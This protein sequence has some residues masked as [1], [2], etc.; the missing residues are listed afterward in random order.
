MTPFE[1][2]VLG[3]LQGVTEFLPISSSGHLVVAQE[4]MGLL[5]PDILFEVVVHMGTLAS[6]LVV[7]KEVI[8][9]LLT[10]W[11]AGESKRM[12]GYLVLGTLPIALAGPV[13][14]SRVE[15][16]FQDLRLVGFAFLVTGTVLILTSLVS[17]RGIPNDS[18]R[19]FLIGVGQ[20]VALVPGISRSGITIGV[21]LL[22]GM[23]PKEAA[24]FSFLLAIP[25]LIG[26]GVLITRD[27]V[28]FGSNTE[29]VV[30]LA[31]GF[32]SAFGV[33]VISLRFLLR[34]LLK[35]RF[36]WFG[37]YCLALGIISIWM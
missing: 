15:T 13:F 33:G 28:T 35:G 10:H 36:H 34:I 1:A 18:K 4:L 11:S 29:S 14:K 17:S 25:S 30:V 5:S 19:S 6:I 7:F 16:M 9:R 2:A 26:S 32:L 20:A 37:V 24:R 21:G 3:I 12:F 31:V 23:N 27:F 8:V 22:L